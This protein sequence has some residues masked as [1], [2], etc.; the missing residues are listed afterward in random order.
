MAATHYHEP[1][2]RQEGVARSEK[3]AVTVACL[4]IWLLG[5]FVSTTVTA[6]DACFVVYY[7]WRKDDGTDGIARVFFPLSYIMTT[8]SQEECTEREKAEAGIE[9]QNIAMWGGR[10]NQSTMMPHKLVNADYFT[11]IFLVYGEGFNWIIIHAHFFKMNFQFF[12]I[13]N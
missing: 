6:V 13:Y 9:P 3:S 12:K 5:L 2:E 7:S 1:V 11:N 4:K 8:T 10:F